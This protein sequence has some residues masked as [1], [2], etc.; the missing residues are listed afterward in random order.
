MFKSK[1][2]Q[3]ISFEEAISDDWSSDFE[4]T[5]TPLSPRS[6]S[7]LWLSVFVLGVI[8]VGRFTYLNFFKGG[9]YTLRSEANS[10]NLEKILAPRGLIVD[11]NGQVLAENRPVFLA[12][13]RLGEFTRS[14]DIQ[15]STLRALSEILELDTLEILDQ[16][17]SGND[18]VL[19]DS[20][21]LSPDL[22]Q[23]QLV[24]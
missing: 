21:V 15:A 10:A 13:L 2:R 7:Y 11:R 22:T 4:V 3:D 24:R 18:A 16:I 12:L 14:G 6:L 19:G 5:E 1:S 9:F 8:I 23:D 17:K 20:I